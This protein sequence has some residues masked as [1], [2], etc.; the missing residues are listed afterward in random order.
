MIVTLTGPTAAGKSTVE[1]ELQRRGLG[2][3]ISHTT[4]L[5]RAG[6]INGQHYHFVMDDEYDRL[7][8]NGSFIETI[9]LGSARYAMS[10]LALL[11]AEQA[12][13]HVAIVVEPVGAAQIH[14]YCR[15]LGIPSL[16][17]W[18]DCSV[19]EQA[20]RWI[21]RLTGD[22]LAGKG[23]GAYAERLALMLSAEVDWREDATCV[24]LSPYQLQLDSTHRSPGQLAD[25]I[26][27]KLSP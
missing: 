16:A 23:V 3:A 14:E 19:K 21:A 27:A 17:V 22:L 11:S 15:K 4:R 13:K 24:V 2:R 10:E 9:H 8:R 7:E 5:P 25:D 20:R 1:A 26:L 6:E 18:I 12:C